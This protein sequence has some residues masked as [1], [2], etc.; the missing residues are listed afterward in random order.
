MEPTTPSEAQREPVDE[1]TSAPTPVVPEPPATSAPDAATP[2][3]HPAGSGAYGAR[4]PW[5]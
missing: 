1:G 2:V 5:E 4:V 3:W